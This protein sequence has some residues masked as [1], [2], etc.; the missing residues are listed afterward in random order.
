MA[1]KRLKNMISREPLTFLVDGQPLSDC[2]LSDTVGGSCLI[3]HVPCAAWMRRAG[4]YPPS[5]QF[6]EPGIV[7]SISAK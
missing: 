5:C 6:L 3:A 4:L 2:P 1:K 7:V